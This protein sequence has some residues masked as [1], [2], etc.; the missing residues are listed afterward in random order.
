VMIGRKLIK[1]LLLTGSISGNKNVK[2][3]KTEKLKQRLMPMQKLQGSRP[4]K[5]K[6]NRIDLK[7]KP[8]KKDW[9]MKR[10]PK[11]K[12]HAKNVLLMRS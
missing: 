3:K 1:K 4:K 8:K 11:K 12:L 5:I 2:S 6:R 10:P 7:R 9:L